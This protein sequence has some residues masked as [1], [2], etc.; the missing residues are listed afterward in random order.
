MGLTAFPNGISSFGV[1]IVGEGLPKLRKDAKYIFVDGDVTSGTGDGKSVNT[2]WTT[3]TEALSDANDWDVI[4]IAP[5]D[6]DEGA[7][8]AVTQEGLTIVGS[9]DAN[10]HRSMLYSSSASHHLMTI[11]AHNVNI[12][13]MGFTQTKDTYS[14]IMCSTTGSYFKIR[15]SNCRFDGYGA[16]EYGIHSGTTYD[17][18]DLTID[19]NVFRSWQTA[20]IYS[21]ATRFVIENNKIDNVAAKIGIHLPATGSNRGGGFCV[22]NYILGHNSTD[23]GISVGA[24]NAGMLFISGNWCV[25][26]GTA[27]ITQ[28]ANGEHS[29]VENYASGKTGGALIDIDSD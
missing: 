12:F 10:R 8:L 14:G 6:Y 29:G 18:P 7:V 2:A 26:H 24:V 25:G 9:G 22:N 27:N 17:S 4:I 11:N 21:Y 3:I 1:P 15:I 19:N 23:T 20:A 13:N 5:G 28:F 16:G